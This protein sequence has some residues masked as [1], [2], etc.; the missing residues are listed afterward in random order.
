[1]L[2]S[3]FFFFTW[4][5]NPRMF[6]STLT[7]F[8]LHSYRYEI[9]ENTCSEQKNITNY[10]PYT[11]IG[12]PIPTTLNVLPRLIA[13][14]MTPIPTTLNVLP[15]L[16]AYRVVTDLQATYN[17]ARLWHGHKDIHLAFIIGA[18]PLTLIHFLH[19]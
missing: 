7:V 9:T 1:M 16:I 13:N 18:A 11:S 12:T 4:Q 2:Q 15:R 8:S 5:A 14:I 3:S 17:Y 10:L 6:L 19:C